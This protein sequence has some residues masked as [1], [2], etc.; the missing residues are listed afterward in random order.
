MASCSK[1]QGEA[2]ALL[3]NQCQQSFFSASLLTACVPPFQW[4]FQNFG[5]F[6]NW[7]TMQIPIYPC[8]PCERGQKSLGTGRRNPFF[9]PKNQGCHAQLH[10]RY[11]KPA[12]AES[13]LKEHHSLKA[14]EADS[15]WLCPDYFG[16]LAFLPTVLCI[17]SHCAAANI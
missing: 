6:L 11:S 4:Y 9:G 13:I 12:K 2:S 7:G 3:S 1:A 17:S 8:G 5:Y 16:Y 15:T 10:T 14:G